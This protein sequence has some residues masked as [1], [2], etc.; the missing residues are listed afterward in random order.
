MPHMS[1]LLNVHQWGR[2][3]ISMQ[4]M[5]SLASTIWW[6]MLYTEDNDA[7]TDNDDDETWLQ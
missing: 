5:N 7:K 3:L 6:A 4:H 1:K 2:I